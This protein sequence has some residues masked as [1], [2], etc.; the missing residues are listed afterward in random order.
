MNKQPPNDREIEKLVL[1]A[2]LVDENS[3]T[4][5]MEALNETCFYVPFHRRIFKAIA[6]MYVQGKGIDFITVTDELRKQGHIK[7]VEREIYISG[8]SGN[9]GTTVNLAHHCKMLLEKAIYRR[10]IVIAQTAETECYAEA[11]TGEAV[12]ARLE[13][14]LAETADSVLE[15]GYIAMNEAVNEATDEIVRIDSSVGGMLGIRTGYSTIDWQIRGLQCGDVICLA[16]RTGSGKTSFALNIAAKIAKNGDPV[17]LFSLEMKNQRLIRRLLQSEAKFNL[18]QL[19]KNTLKKADWE[20]FY[21]S[22]ERLYKLP[23]YLVDNGGITIEE[24]SAKAKRIYR[25]REIKLLIVDY[26]QLVVTIGRSQEG[27]SVMYPAA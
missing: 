27:K 21:N 7:D 10:L 9:V 16:G 22:A 3:R 20:R 14:Q 18:Q 17:A 19:G 8:L 15:K 2:L 11:D 24:L 25:E 5:A 12:I 26:L 4:Q 1:G 6:E 23:I 13:K